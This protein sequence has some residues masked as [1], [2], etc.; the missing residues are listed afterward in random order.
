MIAVIIVVIL[1]LV[2]VIVF[3]MIIILLV[4]KV[5]KNKRYG[6][7]EL[8]LAC[9]FSYCSKIIIVIHGI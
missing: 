8:V 2:M 3:V 9:S 7:C 4:L 6:V 5:Q 1:A